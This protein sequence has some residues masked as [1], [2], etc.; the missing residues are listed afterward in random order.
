MNGWDSDVCVCMSTDNDA[1]VHYQHSSIWILCDS[2]T[3]QLHSY[4]QRPT[5]LSC[6]KPRATQYL[7]C[8]AAVARAGDGDALLLTSA[9]IDAVLANFRFVAGRQHVQVRQQL[10]CLD[11]LHPWVQSVGC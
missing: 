11:N 7:G 6:S 3:A 2:K 9:D 4:T 5:T 8:V 10:T 1:L